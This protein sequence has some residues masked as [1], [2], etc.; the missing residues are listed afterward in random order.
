MQA[1]TTENIIN[2]IIDD[3]KNQSNLSQVSKTV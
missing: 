1:V 2:G 3:L